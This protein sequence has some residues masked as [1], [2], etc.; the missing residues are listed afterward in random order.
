MIHLVDLL[1]QARPEIVLVLGLALAA[2][3]TGHILLTKDDVT[4]AVGWIGLVWFSPFIGGL[5]YYVL[6]INRVRRRALRLR[7][8]G[9]IRGRKPRARGTAPKNADDPLQSLLRGVQTITRRPSEPGCTITVLNNGDETYP[10]MLNAI[11]GAQRSIGMSSYIWRPDKTGLDFVAAL[12]AARKRGV[13]VRVIVDG[14]GSGWLHSPAFAAL[15][16]AGIPAGRFMHSLVPW[17]MPFLNLRSHKKILVVDGTIGFTGGINIADQNILVPPS[18]HPVQDTHFRLTGPVV[19]QLVDAFARDWG[20]VSG[21]VLSGDIWSAAPDTEPPGT[22]LARIVTAGPDQDLE[23]IEQV[24]LEALAC[25]QT[26]IRIITP[27]FL[28]ESRLMTALSLAAMRGVAVDII[29]PLKGDHRL[30]DW[31][32]DAHI[33]PLLLD[34][35]RIWRSP[36]PFRHSKAMVVDESWNLIGSSNWDMR[37]FRLNFELCVEVVD[38]NLA[39]SLSKLMEDCRGPAVTA[40]A[41]AA[42]SLPA[43]LRGAAV[44]LLLPYL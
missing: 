31:A 15:Q 3:I 19:G 4:A 11:A 42:R 8:K 2:F 7:D 1:G 34:G 35:V 43:R 24:V 32:T 20:F 29:L 6:G 14:I 30:V 10:A 36:S 21:E 9:W 40:S 25:A 13:E 16:R 44:R 18:P 28:P 27:Y 22:A 23:K 41:L 39:Q 26:S 37:S 5:A 33:R 12:E 17:R 38:T